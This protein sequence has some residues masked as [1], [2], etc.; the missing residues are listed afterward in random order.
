MKNKVS[1]WIITVILSV[2]AIYVLVATIILPVVT[3]NPLP[4]TTIHAPSGKEKEKPQKEEK[5]GTKEEKIPETPVSHN[6]KDAIKQLF[7]L[8]QQEVLLQSRLALAKEDSM[9]LVLDLIDHKAILEMKGIPLHEC[10]ILKSDVSNSI[11]MYHT[12]RLLNWMSEPFQVKQVDATIPKISFVEKIAPKDSTEANKAAAEP[13]PVKLG[14]VYI[15]MDFERNLRL[16]IE[17]SE[18]PDKE[19]Q[20]L[21]NQLRRKYQGV[22]IRRSLQSLYKFNR[23]PAMPQIS[24]VLPKADATILYKALPL[25]LKVIIRM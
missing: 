20:K 5:T 4:K 13:A 19:G 18:K 9:Y 17:Q 16:V 21:I 12:E 23:E 24:I 1:F 22:E 3:K 14:D 10:T 6:S 2:L 15:V 8:R 7:E 11:R 25:Y